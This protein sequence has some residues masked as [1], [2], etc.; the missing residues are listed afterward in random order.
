M[1][2]YLDN[3]CFN[4]PFDDQSHVRVRLETEAKLEIQARI[5]RGEL[6]LVW[7]YIIEFENQANPFDER[8]LAVCGWKGRALVDIAESPGIVIRAK[9]FV[10]EGLRPKDALHLACAVDAKSDVFLTT[11]DGLLRFGKG[12]EGVRVMNPVDF[13]VEAKT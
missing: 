9:E 3:C 2:I 4:R 12:R 10:K 8:R 1:K 6:A 7:S 5:L 13:V 11:D